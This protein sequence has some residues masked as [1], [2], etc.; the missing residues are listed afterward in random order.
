MLTVHLSEKEIQ[1]LTEEIHALKLKVSTGKLKSVSACMRACACACMSA[2]MSAVRVVHI[3][4]ACMCTF[5]CLYAG[6]CACMHSC[7]RASERTYAN[8]QLS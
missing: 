5:I 7:V 6:V 2:G 4:V 8:F 3:I 1:K